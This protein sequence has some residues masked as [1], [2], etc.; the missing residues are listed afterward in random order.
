MNF[1][2]ITLSQDLKALR[3]FLDAVES[4]IRSLSV[5][6]VDSALYGSFLSSVLLNKL[7]PDL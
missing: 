3:K 6:G 5:L 1:E 7:S 4:I 2:P